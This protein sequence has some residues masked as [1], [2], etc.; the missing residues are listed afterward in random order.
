M[1]TSP[2]PITLNGFRIKGE[3][4]ASN[5]C[6]PLKNVTCSPHLITR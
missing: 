6:D 4:N 3:D 1:S 5:F 2:I